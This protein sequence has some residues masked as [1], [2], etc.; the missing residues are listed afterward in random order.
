MKEKL[1]NEILL[2]LNTCVD[3]S[4]LQ[5][6]DHKLDVILADYEVG[7]RKTEIIPYEY[8]LPETLEIYIVT[9]KI[10]GLS[11]DT[12][13][14]YNLILSDFFYTVQKEPEKITA[15]D[16]RVYLYKYQQNN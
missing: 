15:N 11:A 9:K 6:I 1:K 8:K 2:M 5:M 3:T 13:Y 12:L 16:I 10:G 14:L 4:T 7:S